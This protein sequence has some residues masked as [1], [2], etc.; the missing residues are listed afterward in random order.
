MKNERRKK[1]VT[2]GNSV[3]LKISDKTQLTG[4]MLKIPLL[5][6]QMYCIMQAVTVHVKGRRFRKDF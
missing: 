5:H 2:A 3:F 1:L 6:W 4:T